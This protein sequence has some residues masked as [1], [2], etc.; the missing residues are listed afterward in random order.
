MVPTV[1]SFAG[2]GTISQNAGTTYE[3]QREA[4][5][6]ERKKNEYNKFQ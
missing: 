2:L 5:K 3:L 1:L 6:I 4:E